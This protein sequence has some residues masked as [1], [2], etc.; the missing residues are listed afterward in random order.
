MTGKEAPSAERISSVMNLWQLW[1]E[2]HHNDRTMRAMTEEMR[3]NGGTFVRFCRGYRISSWRETALVPTGERGGDRVVGN[4]L[5]VLK[6][7]SHN[8]LPVFF[9]PARRRK[10]AGRRR[11]L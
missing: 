5:E 3:K 4:E 6:H 11:S 1:L 2:Q 7:V 10:D 9:N 8:I